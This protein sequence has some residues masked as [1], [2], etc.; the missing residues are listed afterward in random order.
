[1]SVHD[2]NVVD[3]GT[4]PQN[5]SSNHWETKVVRFHG[6]ETLPIGVVPITN[7]SPEF[8]CCGFQW[9]LS[10]IKY[11]HGSI[12]VYLRNMT[13][14]DVTINW[15]LSMRDSN[16]GQVSYYSP[17]ADERHF[18]ALEQ[19]GDPPRDADHWGD[20]NFADTSTLTDA[21]EE[22]T[23][24]IEVRMKRDEPTAPSSPMPFIPKNPI[25]NNIL[26]SFNV[27]E[28]ADVVFEVG[29][30]NQEGG[31]SSKKA[32]T[33]TNLYAHRLVLKDGAPLLAELCKPSAG[34]GSIATVSIADVKPDI[35]R[36]MLYYVYGGK[37]AEEELKMNAKD[38]IDAC[39]KYGVVGLKLEAEACYVKS[40]TTTID[41]MMDN[42]L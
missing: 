19:P 31:N 33:S 32:K 23:L 2:S 5:L 25:T 40:T 24:T 21:L 36:H 30:G 1:M 3:V 35:F 14:E 9:C 15:E 34:G 39:D 12:G 6:F 27:E 38:I 41:N 29:S 37:L 20:P 8:S 42:L 4:P 16:G 28:S 10:L 26:K 17:P 11:Q 18:D 13:N 22:G 7:F